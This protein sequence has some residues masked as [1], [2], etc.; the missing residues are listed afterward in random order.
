[1]SRV[2]ASERSGRA[3]A[4]QVVA[5]RGSSEDAP[6]HTLP[7]YKRAIEDGADALECDVRLTATATW[8]ACTTA[9]STARPTAAASCPPS[10]SPS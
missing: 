9:G 2:M 4:V 5:H 8:S 1:M 10:S 6:E 7:A 3:A